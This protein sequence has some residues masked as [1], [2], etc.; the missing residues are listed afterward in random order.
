MPLLFTSAKPLPVAPLVAMVV[1]PVVV[2]VVVT[3]PEELGDVEELVDKEVGAV[4]VR[5]LSK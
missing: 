1:A 5:T 3:A 2:M 4:D